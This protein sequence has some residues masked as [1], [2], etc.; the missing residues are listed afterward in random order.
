MSKETEASP[1]LTTIDEGSPQARPSSTRGASRSW[2]P[3]F[4]TGIVGVALGVVVGVAFAPRG[5]QDAVVPPAVADGASRRVRISEQLARNAGVTVEPIASSTIAPVLDLVGTVD[6]DQERV[7]DVGGRIEGRIVRMMVSVGDRVEEGQALAQIEAP[8]LGEAM[9]E[10]L[11]ASAR[12]QAAR[13]GAARESTLHQRQ[14]TTSGTMETAHA[15]AE[16]LEAEVRGAQQRLLALGITEGEL[17]QIERSDTPVRR[18]TLRSP[19]AGEVIERHAHLGQVVSSTE[20]VLRVADLSTVWVNLEVYERDLA[21][22]HLG[23]NAEILFEGYPGQGFSGT[24]S[25]LDAT[26]DERT[27]SAGVRIVVNNPERRL[28]PGHFVH[29]LLSTE[30][31]QREGIMLSRGAI[32]QLDGQ[33][34]IFVAHADHEYEPRAIELGGSVGERV[35]VLAGIA[36]GERVVVQG[37]FAIKSE[38]QR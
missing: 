4:A 3:P 12:L 21:R 37:G 26:I 31:E 15:T 30:S 20:P 9:A 24:V 6:F 1:A 2:A 32:V 7:A 35:E 18:I 25:Y 33:P 8:E 23:D 28:R 5:V 29:A 10:L 27:R 11:S 13:R 22:V 19:I 17:R 16:A 34:S 38:M 14:L 36:A